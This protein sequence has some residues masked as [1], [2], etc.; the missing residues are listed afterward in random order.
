MSRPLT[1]KEYEWMQKIE[2]VVDRMWDEMT[3]FE[4]TFIEDILERFRKY[5][6]KTFISEKQWAI[7]TR[8][9][10]KIL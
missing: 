8:I 2:E 7:I 1:D 4:Q 5:G 10:E 6:S 3:A 9:S